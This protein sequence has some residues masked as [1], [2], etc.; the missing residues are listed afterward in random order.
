MEKPS[1]LGFA[2][3]ELKKL[4]LYETYY[5]KL[6]PYFGQNKLNLHYLDCDSFVLSSET[7][8]INKD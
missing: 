2:I 7:Q 6:Q 5:E 1:Y 8:Y 3:R 4:Y